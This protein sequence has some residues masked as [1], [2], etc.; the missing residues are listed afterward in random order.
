MRK[1]LDPIDLL[2]ALIGVS[3]VAS[4]PET[5]AM[6]EEAG[7]CPHHRFRSTRN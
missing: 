1:D 6:R 4:S 3:G 5:A 7:G 2:W